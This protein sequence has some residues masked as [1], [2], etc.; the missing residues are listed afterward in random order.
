MVPLL[1]GGVPYG[2]PEWPREIPARADVDA[3]QSEPRGHHAQLSGQRMRDG[4]AHQT[5]G[6][7]G[8]VRGEIVIA[9]SRRGAD[10][11]QALKDEQQRI[12]R[13]LA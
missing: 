6:M 7:A 8:D 4:D 5:P 11:P 10:L 13:A 3:R 1:A 12:A 2:R 9:R